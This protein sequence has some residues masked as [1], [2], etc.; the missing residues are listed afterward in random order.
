MI[1]DDIERIRCKECGDDG[2]MKDLMKG[3]L[4]LWDDI[5]YD[6]PQQI[7]CPMCGNFVSVEVIE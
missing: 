1:M 3:L 2:G 5:G 4:D 7:H 6:C